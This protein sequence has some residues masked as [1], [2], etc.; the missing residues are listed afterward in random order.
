MDSFLFF[1]KI[2]ELNTSDCLCDKP[3]VLLFPKLHIMSSTGKF[4]AISKMIFIS[5]L[6]F[7]F[8][9]FPNAC[10]KYL[11]QISDFYVMFGITKMTC[12]LVA[13]I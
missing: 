11:A 7:E 13:G 3:T 6:D 10:P 2:C 1:N 9:A 8:C 12:N 4:T 5:V